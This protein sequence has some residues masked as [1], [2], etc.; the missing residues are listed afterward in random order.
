VGVARGVRRFAESPRVADGDGAV[1]REIHEERG[2]VLVELAMRITE[3]RDLAGGFPIEHQRGRDAIRVAGLRRIAERR[4]RRDHS[5]AREVYAGTLY[6]EE[7]G[8]VAREHRGHVV[9]F[10]RLVD[11]PHHPGESVALHNR[12]RQGQCHR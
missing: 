10:E 11:L 5:I 2:V 7:A 9:D 1:V 3:D 4:R 8:G 12:I 6:A